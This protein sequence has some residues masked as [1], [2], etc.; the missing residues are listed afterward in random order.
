MHIVIGSVECLIWGPSHRFICS[1]KQ[2]EANKI[3]WNRQMTP[4]LTLSI[5]TPSSLLQN[6]CRVFTKFC[7]KFGCC[8]AKL[9]PPQHS[10]ERK[11]QIISILHSH[12]LDTTSE[13][14]LFIQA[15][16]TLQSQS[17]SCHF[18]R[19]CMCRTYLSTYQG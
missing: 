17:L 18:G 11:H 6:Q 5:C 16:Y 10:F 12:H 3:S 1:G 14:A 13:Y 19:N 4:C 7:V 9:R 8:V 2:G 15:K